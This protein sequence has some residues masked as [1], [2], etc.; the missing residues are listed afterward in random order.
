MRTGRR[1]GVPP[2]GLRYAVVSGGTGV[3]S[4][5]RGLIGTDVP[6]VLGVGISTP[7]VLGGRLG[8]RG[9]VVPGGGGGPML[10]DAVSGLFI[11][12]PSRC[13]Y[14]TL[15]S[16]CL[17]GRVEGSP[18]RG[19]T[20]RPRPGRCATV[21]ALRYGVTDLVAGSTRTGRAEVAGRSL[22]ATARTSK[23]SRTTSGTTWPVVTG[24]DGAHLEAKAESLVK[25]RG[26]DGA[27]SAVVEGAHE[28]GRGEQ[29]GEDAPGDSARPGVGADQRP[30]RAPRA[31]GCLEDLLP[32]GADHL[33]VGRLGPARAAGG[34]DASLGRRCRRGT[35][36]TGSARGLLGRSRGACSSSGRRRGDTGRGGGGG[37]CRPL[38]RDAV[39]RT[40]PADGGAGPRGLRSRR[41]LRGGCRGRGR[42]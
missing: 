23:P 31:L 19:R 41:R 29:Q 8:N 42:S 12:G 15:R 2:A 25:G 39:I 40:V 10:L 26:E 21:G 27:V 33:C 1:H 24:D 11:G 18:M 36:R 20:A 28:A 30:G 22:R 9:A 3:L 14:R 17:R 37:A 38:G 4:G 5:T 35:D 7:V 16:R 6:G 34:A 32:A 13:G